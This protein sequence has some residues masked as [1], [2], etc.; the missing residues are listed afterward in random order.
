MFHLA[1]AL[2]LLATLSAALH[3]PRQAPSCPPDSIENTANFSLTAVCKEDTT[4]SAA[5]VV[6]FQDANPSYVVSQ[7]RI[8]IPFFTRHSDANEL[9]CVQA[10]GPVDGLTVTHL[11]MINGTIVASAEGG[12]MN[13]VSE[14]TVQPDNQVLFTSVD[15]TIPAPL[16]AGP[17]CAQVSSDYSTSLK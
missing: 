5:L 9:T 10:A 12:T 7:L 16:P 4:I 13:A 8:F 14:S 2:L 6:V 15:Q 3:V 17:F 11:Q 1:F